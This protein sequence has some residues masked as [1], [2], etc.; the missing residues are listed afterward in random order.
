M[1]KGLTRTSFLRAQRVVPPSA[2]SLRARS[3][4]LKQGSSMP[5]HSTHNR[6]EL[7]IVLRGHVQLE[8]QPRPQP[9]A[10]GG[11]GRIRTTTVRAGQCAFLPS[12]TVHQIVNRSRRQARYVYVTA[13]T[14]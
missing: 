1:V 2:L 11:A 10:D 7:I 4:M 9:P 14:T 3:V 13:P 8:T 12:Y 6:E 5:W